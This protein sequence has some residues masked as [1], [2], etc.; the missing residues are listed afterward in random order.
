MF[1]SVNA[2]GLLPILVLTLEAVVN[3]GR[4]KYRRLSGNCEPQHLQES[5]RDQ[6]ARGC[7]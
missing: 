6:A 2:F 7:P 1:G 4:R 5:T 3:A